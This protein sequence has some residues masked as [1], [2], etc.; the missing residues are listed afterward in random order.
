MVFVQR[1][2]YAMHLC[3]HAPSTCLG[4]T[5]KKGIVLQVLCRLLVVLCGPCSTA[6]QSLACMCVLVQLL[7]LDMQ[8]QCL[9]LT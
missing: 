2:L 1:G 5:Q 3:Q 6:V 8:Q 4:A 7:L 9:T